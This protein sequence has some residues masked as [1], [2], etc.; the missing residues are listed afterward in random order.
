MKTAVDPK[1]IT[2]RLRR[3]A[4]N[5]MEEYNMLENG[6]KIMVCVSLFFQALCLF[7]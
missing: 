2:K 6:D 5:A 1:I 7:L 4:W 3:D